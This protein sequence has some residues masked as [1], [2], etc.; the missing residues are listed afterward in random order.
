MQLEG[1]EEKSHLIFTICDAENNVINQF[2]KEPSE[3]ISR[4]SWGMTYSSPYQV[5]IESKYDPILEA[6]KGIMVMPGK[7]KVGLKLWHEGELTELVS[8]VEFT[9]K[10]LNNT[11]LPAENYPEN[12]AFY[13]KVNKLALA[14]VGTEKMI[15]ETRTKVEQI[16][17]AIYATPGANQTMMDQARTLSVELEELDFVL[18]GSPSKAS[19]EEIPPAQVPLKARLST[20]TSRSSTAGITATEKQG[21]EILKEELPPVLEALKRIVEKEI[22]ALEAELNKMNAPWTSGRFPV[23]E[24]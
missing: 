4:V 22:P 13:E 9:C 16:K 12:I 1:Y 7:Y 14:V 18:K 23:W 10:R 11:T 20:I 19:D 3:G 2:S 8:P 15:A 24:E 17:Q 6:G 21:Y 5:H